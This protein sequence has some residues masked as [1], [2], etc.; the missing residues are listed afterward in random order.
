[1]GIF[2]RVKKFQKFSSN[3]KKMNDIE[4]AVFVENPRGYL[5]KYYKNKLTE[6]GE[7]SGD[8]AVAALTDIDTKINAYRLIEV[9]LAQKKKRMEDGLPE[10]VNSLEAVRHLLATN[11]KELPTN[12]ELTE[13]VYKNA[14]IENTGKVMLFIGANIA[15]EYDTAEAEALLSKNKTEAKRKI[16]EIK[17]ELDFLSE[18]ILISEMSKARIVSWADQN[19]K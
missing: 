1:M 4:K 14:T 10:T 13:G 12:F 15:L 2:F 18:Q 9:S 7:V 3:N 11:K 6:D 17:S 5:K 16:D 8:A 19:E